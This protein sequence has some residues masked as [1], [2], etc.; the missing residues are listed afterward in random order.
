MYV[1]DAMLVHRE[2]AAL[3]APAYQPEHVPTNDLLAA[4]RSSWQ[5]IGVSGRPAPPS[6]GIPVGR[7]VQTGSPVG[8]HRRR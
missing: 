3:R 1:R 5:W 2:E 4:I 7:S 8:D 6:A